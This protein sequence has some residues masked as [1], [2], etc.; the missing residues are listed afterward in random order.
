M[1][2]T[3]L[4][5]NSFSENP[6]TTI[7]DYS[8]NLNDGVG[9]STV[10]AADTVGYYLDL[11]G[12]NDYY[13]VANSANR[14][15]YTICCE[16]Y[17]EA[18]SGF[19][20]NIITTKYSAADEY[21]FWIWYESGAIYAWV[22]SS[23]GASTQVSITASINTW[24]K[25][26]YTYSGGVGKL[27]VDTIDSVQTINRVQTTMDDDFFIGSEP[28][29]ANYFN[30]RI[31]DMRFYTSVVSNDFIKSF[32]T[33]SKGMY[34]PMSSYVTAAGTQYPA[35]KFSVG[36]LIQ[37][38]SPASPQ[39]CVYAKTTTALYVLPFNDVPIRDKEQFNR[40]GHRWDTDRQYSIEVSQTDESINCHNGVAKFSIYN[41]QGYHT[42]RIYK[43]GI[44]LSNVVTSVSYTVK[45]WDNI[46]IIDSLS[47]NVTITLP[48]AGDSD[49]RCWTIKRV[50]G[51]VNTVSISG[52][53]DIDGEASIELLQYDSV[54]IYSNGAIYFII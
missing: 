30:G 43:D 23:G 27:Y 4:F 34:I 35:N 16:V 32:L 21:P 8:E 20:A 1:A 10:C 48:N 18:Y 25:V 15:S 47:G 12:A 44:Y 26:V 28:L 29:L 19:Y 54:T 49:G 39:L 17:P 6:T 2:S 41:S 3:L 53:E 24:H 42:T 45:K 46:I 7:R 52:D 11:D 13:T 5:A 50:D 14:T 38:D 37:G 22:E 36:D 9:V 33:N 51:S 31:R 40:I